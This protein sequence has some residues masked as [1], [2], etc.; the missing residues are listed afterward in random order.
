M[1]AE[2]FHYLQSANWKNSGKLVV[3]FQP[4]TESLGTREADG[5]NHSPKAEETNVPAQGGESISP[6]SSAFCS[7]QALNGLDNDH[8]YREGPPTLLIPPI[9]MLILPRNS[10][11][12]RPE[13]KI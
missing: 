11:I 12:C 4:E 8:P 3:S 5:E 7:I 9:Q 13:H 2:N 1:E 10:L 6:F